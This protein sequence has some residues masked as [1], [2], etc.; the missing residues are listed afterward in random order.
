[1]IS[2]QCITINGGVGKRKSITMD[3]SSKKTAE[4]TNKKNIQRISDAETL[5]DVSQ[6]TS[7]MM[8]LHLGGHILLHEPVG[9]SKQPKPVYE[10]VTSCE[11]CDITPIYHDRRWSGEPQAYYYGYFIQ[12]DCASQKQ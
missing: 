5:I 4:R 8:I 3:T 11:K 10:Y 2:A 6:P 12:R 1:V 7:C 9:G